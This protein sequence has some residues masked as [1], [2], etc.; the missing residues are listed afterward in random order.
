MKRMFSLLLSLSLCL[1]LTAQ[2]GSRGF[3]IVEERGKKQIVVKWNGQLLTAY[4]YYDSVFKPFLFPLNTVDG[5]AVTRGY[6]LAPV[7][8]ERT[9]H[10]H[11]TGLWM[12]YESVNGLDFW[13]NSTDIAPE[14]RKR[15]GTIRHV[16]L[17]NKKVSGSKARI[18]V[19]ANWLH[20]D[21]HVLM[22]EITAYTFTVK[23]RNFFIDRT[24]TLTATGEDVIFKD[25]KDG[26][27]AIR[28]ARE[29]EMPSTQADV[30]VD[31]SGLKTTV[32]KMDNKGVT[33]MYYNSDGVT[34]DSVWST[35]GRWAMLKG[36]K[37][38]KAITIGI[39]DHPKN[40]GYPGY[41]HARGYGLFALNPLGRKVFSN[42]GEELNF[43]LKKNASTTF[44]YKVM[45]SSGTTVDAAAMNTL[46]NAFAK[47]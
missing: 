36:V 20:P 24:S 37:G 10:P 2:K 11:H 47:E 17:L 46:A 9:D 44:R 7:E 15:Y 12:N 4:C 40:V 13:N 5:I 42:G 16:A 34:G 30:F 31:A 1:A 19:E 8:G 32:K 22:K 28:V 21:G 25:V 43:T 23:G 38:G 14:N 3:S 45:I 27:L 39:F 35:K 18:S 6:P 26:F 41:W 29:L 33:G